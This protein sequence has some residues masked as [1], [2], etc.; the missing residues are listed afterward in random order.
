[1]LTLEGFIA[2]IS[3]CASIYCI[4]YTNGKKDTKK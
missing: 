3:L 4:G 1:M 2:V